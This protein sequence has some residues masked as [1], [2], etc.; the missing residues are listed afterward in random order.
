MA[1][2]LSLLETDTVVKKLTESLHL[3]ESA[4]KVRSEYHGTA[5]SDDV[6]NITATGSSDSDAVRR[7]NAVAH[8][9]LAFRQHVYQRQSE[10]V[11]K[12]L[13][14]R[15]RALQT[16]LDS[17][18]TTVSSL[19]PS[20]ISNPGQTADPQLDQLLQRRAQLSTEILSLQNSIQANA[21][22]SALVVNGSGVIDAA[23]PASGSNVFALLRNMASGLAA[24]LLIGIGAVVLLSVTSNRVWRREDVARALRAPVARSVGR[25][26]VRRFGRASAMRSRLRNP[27]LGMRTIDEHLLE[28]LPSDAPALAIVSVDSLDVGVLAACL[29]TISLDKRGSRVALVDLT[30]TGLPFAVLGVT[31]D[32]RPRGATRATAP[33][34]TIRPPVSNS[35]ETVIALAKLDPAV[36][37]DHLREFAARSVVFVTAGRSTVNTLCATSDMLEAAGIEVHSVVLAD[38]SRYDDSLGFST[39]RSETFSRLADGTD[40]PSQNVAS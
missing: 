18:T 32:V 11:G 5:P 29:L 39:G 19:S 24:G 36:G 23:S 15:T 7:A 1:T 14:G 25:I 28:A 10:V 40:V 17:V 12:A 6:L 21:I 4:D 16:E 2:D 20:A 9:F 31:R 34:V 38:A 27:G 37:A 22:S 8:A 33:A 3:H 30:G 35:R 13:E 26:R